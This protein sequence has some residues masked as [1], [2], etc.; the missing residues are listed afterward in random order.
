MTTPDSAYNNTPPASF[1]IR[2][3]TLSDFD[4]IYYIFCNVLEAGETYSYTP[5]EMT[6]DRSL[7]YWMSAPG[8]HCMVAE[9][10]GE[11]A[12][13]AALR[14]NRTGRGGHVVN[15][16]FIVSDTYRGR[17]I[18]RAFGERALALGKSLGYH[19]MQFN[20]VV[21][22]NDIAV[23]LWQSLGFKIVGTLPKGFD[24]AKNGLVDV[25]IMSRSL[26]DVDTD[27]GHL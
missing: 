13:M 15:A 18:A 3:A 22:T 2:E 10:E 25:Y 12:G 21:S 6:P 16:S 19:T 5:E 14:P 4:H 24:H 26:C 20:F 9:V 17:G 23:K 7:A 11:I 8:T 27:G 1:T